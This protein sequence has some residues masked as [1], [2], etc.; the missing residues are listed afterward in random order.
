[1]TW[2]KPSRFSHFVLAGVLI[3]LAACGSPSRPTAS[4]NFSGAALTRTSETAVARVELN[5]TQLKG[6]SPAEITV[7]LSQPAP[8]D[9][10]A[11]DLDSSD[12]SLVL[13]PA[14]ITIPAGRNSTTVPFATKSA[15]AETTVGISATY[16]ESV[17]GTSLTIAPATALPFTVALQ[18][19]SL[20]KS[21]GQSASD[22]VTTKISSGYNHALQ[23]SAANAPAGISVTFTP[24]SIAA[25]GAGTSK[26]GFKVPT[27]MKLGTYSIPIT[28]TDGTTSESATLKLFV[29]KD[30]GATFQGCVYHSSGHAY[31]AAKI[32]VA[33][34]GT[35][36][37]DADLYWGATCDPTQ[38]ADEFGYGTPVNFGG[39]GYLWWFADFADQTGTSA[40]WHV[41]T[42]TS[43]CVNY[44]VAPSC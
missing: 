35:Y 11:I 8:A 16:R 43:K 6:G 19:A 2:R 13:I 23:L 34:P 25:P 27:G 3:E 24:P 32:S 10:A 26:A 15:G 9:G 40:I 36:R 22:K 20:T 41:G 33:N 14:G 29:V 28:A 7:Y 21:P 12:D 42:D 37:F 18:S 1:M 38:K 31:Q 5:S 44:A 39:F 30:P 17:A 4:G